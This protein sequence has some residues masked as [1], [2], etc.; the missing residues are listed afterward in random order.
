MKFVI[1]EGGETAVI[2]PGTIGSMQVILA[3]KKQ[4]LTLPTSAIHSA[5]DKHYVYVVGENNMREVKWIEVGLAG[6]DKVEIV[7]GLV[8]GEKVIL[9]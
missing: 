1:A 7:S 2:E 8:E 9:K 4:V 6:K 5:D 3:E